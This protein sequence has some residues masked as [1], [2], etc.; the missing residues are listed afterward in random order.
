[1]ESNLEAVQALLAGMIAGSSIGVFGFLI[2]GP[3]LATVPTTNWIRR[4]FGDPSNWVMV[5]LTI[6]F[7]AQIACAVVGAL[8]GLLLWAAGGDHAGGLGS[9]SWVYTASVLIVLAACAVVAAFFL[10]QRR[11]RIALFTLLT[12]GCLAW[13]LPHLA[14]A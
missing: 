7:S 3:L 5:G 12:A 8:L 1:M 11:R 6:S 2:F 4:Q 9:P 10:P 13:M 14:F